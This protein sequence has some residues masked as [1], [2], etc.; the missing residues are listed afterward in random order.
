MSLSFT[1][2]SYDCSSIVP[3]GLAICQERKVGIDAGLEPRA[4]PGGHSLYCPCVE[5]KPLTIII[6]ERLGYL[7]SIHK[8][9]SVVIFLKLVG[10]LVL[11]FLLL[12][13]SDSGVPW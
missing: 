1:E 7:S 10:E 12:G 9:G 3:V 5:P 4:I 13:R 2:T 11:A 8:T 6:K